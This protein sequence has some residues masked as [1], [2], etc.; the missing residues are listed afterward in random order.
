MSAPFLGQV[1]IFG[2]P[3]APRYW[4]QCAGQILAITQNQ[5]LFSPG[6]DIRRQRITTFALPDL[7]SRV[8]VGAGTDRV[9]VDGPGR[10]AAG[11]DQAGFVPHPAHTH[12][13]QAA[14][15]TAI[16]GG[17]QYPGSTVG[18]GV[19]TGVDKSG[20]PLTVNLYVAADP[21]AAVT[22]D[23]SA[24]SPMTGGQPHENRMPLLPLNVCICLSG[25]FPSRQ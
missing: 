6:H 18:L 14:A 5:A 1:E 15:G 16:T 24:I 9:Q 3:F 7:R 23:A 12:A 8:P 10:P 25:S 11:I 2:F 21:K 17:T 13:L 19:T 22:L 4:A 20:A